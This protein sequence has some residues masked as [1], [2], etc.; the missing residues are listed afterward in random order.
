[1]PY[2]QYTRHPPFALLAGACLN[3]LVISIGTEFI[4][5]TQEADREDCE[6]GAFYHLP[7][8][9]RRCPGCGSACFWMRCI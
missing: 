4:E 9:E 3:G 1:M 7:A 5:K 6:P 8:S 2:R